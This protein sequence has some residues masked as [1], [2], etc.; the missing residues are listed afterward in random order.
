MSKHVLLL[1]GPNLNMLGRR[2]PELYGAA[3]LQDVEASCRD[4][5]GALGLG[6][7]CVQSN[8]EDALIG[9]IHDACDAADGIILNP[10]A[11]S[12]TSIALLDAL[13]IFDGPVLEVHI[14]N[15]HRRETFR[16]QSYISLRADGVI[17]G[18]GIQGYVLALH[19]MAALLSP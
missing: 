19:R 15:I 1:N 17:A 9:H 11:F 10:G 18:C 13:T 3:T 6:L 16:Q 4:T 8:R 2:Q 7:D 12:H 5:A 14:S